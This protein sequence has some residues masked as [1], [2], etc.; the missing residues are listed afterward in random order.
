VLSYWITEKRK[1]VQ[2]MRA[3]KRKILYIEL[4]SI[5][6]LGHLVIIWHVSSCVLF[7][8]HTIFN[9]HIWQTG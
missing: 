6:F 9:L 1:F 5:P 3:C 2:K 4:I 8:Y 7:H